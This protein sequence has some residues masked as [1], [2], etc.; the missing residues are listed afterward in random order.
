MAENMFIDLPIDYDR[1]TGVIIPK[2]DEMQAAVLECI[3][4]RARKK[5]HF[6]DIGCGTGHTLARIFSAY[7][8]AS[9]QAVDSSG[10][11]LAKAQ[12][13]LVAFPAIQWTQADIL[14][15]PYGTA[16]EVAVSVAALNNIDNQF[17]PSIYQTIFAA[18]ADDGLFVHGD[19][20]AHENPAVQRQL[21]RLYEAHVRAG[22]KDE[23][24]L[25][26]WFKQYEQAFYPVTLGVHFSMLE[27]AG[28]RDVHLHWLFGGQAVFSA[29][30]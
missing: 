13:R 29:R 27:A 14:N 9:A 11:M 28:F 22:I 6:L 20:I 3:R 26:F 7:P 1:L 23:A 16:V 4:K 24:F 2:Y 15:A 19:F 17:L 12:A 25:D 8:K 10:M 5:G 21:D 30:K 18:L